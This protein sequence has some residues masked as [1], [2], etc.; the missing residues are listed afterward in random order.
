MQQALKQENQR[1]RSDLMKAREE[2]DKLNIKNAE[3]EETV[4][5]L[6]MRIDELQKENAKIKESQVNRSAI[7]SLNKIVTQPKTGEEKPIIE[8]PAKNP[9]IDRDLWSKALTA[10]TS[11]PERVDD[12]IKRNHDYANERTKKGETLLHFLAA[13]P[14]VDPQK[15]ELLFKYGDIT[16]KR[17]DDN[18]TAIDIA[19]ENGNARFL[20]MCG[21]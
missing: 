13:K 9:A 1:L 15:F 3:L 21:L 4:L 14:N 8:K 20:M 18:K 16:I 5:G 6:K 11:H 10:I 2:I 12:L 7:I 19:R 17:N